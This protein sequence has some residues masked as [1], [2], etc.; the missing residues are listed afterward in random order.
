MN[1]ESFRVMLGILVSVNTIMLT[2]VGII[3]WAVRRAATNG[4]A[5]ASASEFKQYVQ[6]KLGDL[7]K[8]FSEIQKGIGHIET[9]V[10]LIQQRAE[11]ADKDRVNLWREIDLLRNRDPS[12]RTRHDDT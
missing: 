2:V 10:A 3:V 9:H 12:A 1:S 5:L 7:S 6:K 4:A 8:V 11:A